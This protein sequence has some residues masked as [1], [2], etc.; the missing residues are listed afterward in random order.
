MQNPDC[1]FCPECKTPRSGFTQRARFREVDGETRISGWYT[2]CEC[3]AYTYSPG[4]GQYNLLNVVAE[5]HGIQRKTDETV[6]R[7]VQ[8]VVRRRAA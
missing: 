4:N 7:R 3:G 2:G 1:A 6:Q 8:P 5:A